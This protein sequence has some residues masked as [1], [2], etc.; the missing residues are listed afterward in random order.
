MEMKNYLEKKKNLSLDDRLYLVSTTSGR[1]SHIDLDQDKFK[2]DPVKAVLFI[3][4]AKVYELKEDTGECQVN[5][6][7]CLECGTCQVACRE[8]VT[9][10]NPDSGF[11]ANYKFG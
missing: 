11:G 9:W 2:S 8:Y 3:C 1:T 5:F 7:N 6:E 4:P 10:R